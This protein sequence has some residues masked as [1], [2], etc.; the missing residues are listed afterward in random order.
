MNFTQFFSDISR[1]NIATACGYAI[2]VACF[3][4]ATAPIAIPVA[5]A[6]VMTYMGGK[7][8]ENVTTTKTASGE[9]K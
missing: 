9:P 1:P 8:Y 4:P 2:A 5:G 7:T 6:I 3:I